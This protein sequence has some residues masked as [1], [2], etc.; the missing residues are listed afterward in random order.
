MSAAPALAGVVVIELT[1]GEAG[2]AA[3]FALAQLGATV[4]LV[5]PLDGLPLRAEADAQPR[6][7]ALWSA[8]HAN[9]KSVAVNLET[10]AGRELVRAL[11]RKADVFLEDSEAEVERARLHFEEVRRLSPSLVYGTLRP[12]AAPERFNGLASEGMLQAISG[13]LARPGEPGERPIRVH[14]RNVAGVSGTYMAMGLITAL[15]EVRLTGEGQHVRVNEQEIAL[16]PSAAKYREGTAVEP[17]TRSDATA[18]LTLRTRPFGLDDVVQISQIPRM[19]KHQV[20]LLRAM[21]REDIL[22]DPAYQDRDVRREKVAELA[23][24]WAASLTK[25]E[26]V[27]L[28]AR[29]GVPIGM[30]NTTQEVLETDHVLES[31]IVSPIETPTGPVLVPALPLQMSASRVTLQR[32]PHL[33]EHTHELLA[34]IG[35]ADEENSL[36]ERGIVR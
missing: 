2:A 22:A 16:Y 29:E 6:G 36:R 17:L 21:G 8:W 4:V 28:V 31:G 33:G 30:V 15:M 5:E 1:R 25:Q 11:L 26:V 7:E 14:T 20:G 27:E 18:G 12:W 10:E 19:T 34:S 9:K 35:R 13:T 24:E 32:G 3:G 23:T